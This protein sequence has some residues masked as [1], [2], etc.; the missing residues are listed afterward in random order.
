MKKVLFIFLIFIIICSAF[1][2]SSGRLSL[3]VLPEA[4][5]PLGDS[6]DKFEIGFGGNFAA[7]Y[8]P[9]NMSS[10]FFKGSIGYLTIPTIA[11]QIC[12]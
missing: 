5:F 12:L 3:Q 8:I 4:A 9:A 2:Q 11:E 6:A 10:L 7:E 1:P